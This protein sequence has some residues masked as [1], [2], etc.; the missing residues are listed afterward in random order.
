MGRRFDTLRFP[1]D[2]TRAFTLSY[3]DGVIQD[4]RLAELFRKYGAK[5]TFN[6]NSGL[7]GLDRRGGYPGKP[8]LDISTLYSEELSTVYAG[9]EIAGHGFCHSGFN[10]IG[11]P[12]GVYEIAEDK[13]RLEGYV[14]RPLRCK[15]NLEMRNPE[16]QKKARMNLW[17]GNTPK[18]IVLYTVN[19]NKLTL[20]FGTLRSILP[21]LEGDWK[22]L[23]RKPV[24]V[25]Y[26][27]SVP[28]YDY[29]EEA[30]GAI[31]IGGGA[32]AGEGPGQRHREGQDLHL[33]E[34]VQPHHR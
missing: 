1:G 28:L 12:L 19:G 16:Y 21:L 33:G 5:A 8:K 4:R 6:L 9:H 30:V 3:D 11:A 20:P 14:G 26:K 17:L 13:R 10:T 32:G 34:F 2:R 7:L 29:Q 24:K 27:A 31:L 22:Q 23:Y 25:N 15:E 18:K